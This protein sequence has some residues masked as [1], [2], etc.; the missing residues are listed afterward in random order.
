MARSSSA[1]HNPGSHLLLPARAPWSETPLLGALPPLIAGL[2][3]GFD[4]CWT[5]APLSELAAVLVLGFVLAGRFPPLL[6]AHRWR[7]WSGLLGCLCL[8]TLGMSLGQNA[9]L[10]RQLWAQAGSYPG[11]T[12]RGVWLMRVRQAPVLSMGTDAPRSLSLTVRVESVYPQALDQA[13]GGAAPWQESLVGQLIYLQLPAQ[14]LDSLTRSVIEQPG[15]LLLAGLNCQAPEPA[16]HPADFDQRAWL[17]GNGVYAVARASPG[18][19]SGLMPARGFQARL[20]KLRL[21]AIGNLARLIPNPAQAAVLSALSLGWKGDLDART[22][23]AFAR[24][25]TLH[26]LA[27]S[28]LHVG[29]VFL[30]LQSLVRLLTQRLKALR[31]GAS[32]WQYTLRLAEV[33]PACA[34]VWLFALMSGGAPSSLRA[35]LL[36]SLMGLGQ[37]RHR[38]GGGRNAW[39]ATAL[40]LLVA[41]PTLLFSIGFQLSFGAVAGILWTYPLFRS[42][43][44]WRGWLGRHVADLLALSLAAQWGSLAASWYYFGQFPTYFL[45][46]NL[47]GVPLVGLL[48][49]GT[50]LLLILAGSGSALF[51]V[52]ELIGQL[53]IPLC[54][55][56]LAGMERTAALPATLIWLPEFPRWGALLLF[57]TV[58]LF[59]DKTQSA[60]SW[61][62]PGFHLLLVLALAS[63]WWKYREQAPAVL[64]FSCRQGQCTVDMSAGPTFLRLAGALP[65]ELPHELRTRGLRPRIAPDRPA[66]PSLPAPQLAHA[67]VRG[68]PFSGILPVAWPGG[69]LTIWQQDGPQ[70]WPSGS[71]LLI[72]SPFPVQAPPAD[73]LACVLLYPDLNPRNRQRWLR[74]CRENNLRCEQLPAYGTRVWPLTTSI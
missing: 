30:M 69:L 54:S 63:P 64:S 24:S 45:L 52:A 50:G 28:G 1:R 3:L 7:A 32:G 26:V 4:G 36:F 61:R 11:S 72:N 48:L 13:D 40:L 67:Q 31:P 2:L 35:A 62:R 53:L 9:V 37:L 23:D 41:Q 39:A 18:A 27:V 71:W 42:R 73:S 51:P 65:E 21:K 57:G 34:G 38:R 17:A 56:W 5:H 22:R 66:A 46:G 20:H 49:S 74:W 44:V 29:L 15:A 14:R 19:V 47:V 33:L 16:S 68:H 59:P 8:L 10:E 60:A 6:R 58:L 70:S 55:I 25:G 43:M 12:P